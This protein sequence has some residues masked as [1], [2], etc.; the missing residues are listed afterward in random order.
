MSEGAAKVLLELLAM[1]FTHYDEDSNMSC[2]DL[3]ENLYSSL[4]E[5]T[6]WTEYNYAIV[7]GARHQSP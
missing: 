3:A 7:T 5:H 1:Y 2:V 6:R 4:T